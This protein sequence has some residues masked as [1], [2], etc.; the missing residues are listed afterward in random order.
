MSFPVILFVRIYM[1]THPL[2][3]ASR[4]PIGVLSRHRNT[5]NPPFQ[6][7]SAMFITK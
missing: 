3:G 6:R 4:M 5:E 2:M 1:R 7:A